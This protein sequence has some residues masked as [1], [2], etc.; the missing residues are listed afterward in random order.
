MRE[1]GSGTARRP[2]R[3]VFVNEAIGGH[4]TVHAAL[5]THLAE[6][7]DVQAEFFDAPDPGV[8]GRIAGAPIPG[9]IRM[10]ADF[11]PLR[12]QLVR[13][14]GVHRWLRRRLQQGDVDVLHVYTQNCALLSSG[15]L[16][17]VP[18]VVSTDS[19]TAANA[20][21]LPHRLPGRRTPATIKAS[22]PF[23]RS[24]F[25][26]ADRVVAS[27]GWTA[28]MIRATGA[29]DAGRLVVV[30]FGVSLPPPPQERPRRRPT[31]AFIGHHMERKGGNQLLRL[32]QQHL[33]DD[34]DLLLVT[35]DDV[36]DLPGVRVVRDLRSG[37]GRLW[38]LLAGADVFCFPS[39]MDQ[40][41]NAVLEAAA[42]GLPIV[43]HPVAAVPEMVVEGVT[44]LLVPPGDDGALL[45]ALRLL[46]D[47]PA[48]RREMGRQ[49]REHVESHYDMRRTVDALVDVLDEVARAPQARGCRDGS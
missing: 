38:E 11:Q 9:L 48:R 6:R 10:D 12:A 42:A 44:G 3:A 45:A 40:A 20:Y 28:E 14:L 33:R 2:L 1:S 36:D 19:T 4:R 49:A 41:P 46:I 31:I 26:A 39:T 17:Q 5:R 24:V 25:G 8:L 15:L 32:H 37:D 23:E 16:R 35:T 47:D 18:T 7:D 29:V 21:R 30:P 43:A 13:S 34:C 22:V 27:S